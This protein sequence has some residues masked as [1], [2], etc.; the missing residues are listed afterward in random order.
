ICSPN[1]IAFYSGIEIDLLVSKYIGIN[2]AFDVA[3]TNHSEKAGRDYSTLLSDLRDCVKINFEAPE[4]TNELRE[5][6]IKASKYLGNLLIRAY[7][8]NE[9]IYN[10]DKLVE[11]LNS[12]NTEYYNSSKDNVSWKNKNNKSERNLWNELYSRTII[13]DEYF[14]KHKDEMIR[15][16]PE[17][18]KNDIRY[19]KTGITKL[20]NVLELTKVEI[21]NRVELEPKKLNKH[22]KYVGM[23]LKNWKNNSDKK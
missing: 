15:L 2:T 13:M 12:I 9:F 20:K 8:Y 7:K 19:I 14:S 18:A 23:N 1:L 11:D 3:A 22:Q 21:E 10:Q 16:F 17:S 6:W 5:K 4:F